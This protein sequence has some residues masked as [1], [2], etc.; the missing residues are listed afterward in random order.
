MSDLA[1]KE[2]DKLIRKTSKKLKKVYKRA[3]QDAIDKFNAH[4]A[5]FH[6]KEIRYYDDYVRTGLWTEQDYKDWRKN[7][8][9][10]SQRLEE[11]QNIIAEDL[12]NTD[13]IAMKMVRDGEFDVYALNHNYST[14]E[15]ERKL[16]I[17]TSFTLY[18][19][20]AVE[21]LVIDDPELLPAPSEK[22]QAEIDAKDLKWNKEKLSSVFTSAIITGVDIPT[23][24]QKIS[25]V[26]SMDY[27]ASIRNA[28]TMYTGAENR[29]RQDSYTRAQRMGIDIRK[30]WIATLDERTRDSHRAVDG[31]IVELNEKFSNGLRFPGDPDGAPGEVYNCRCAMVSVV[32][33]VDPMAFVDKSD[34]LK[35]KLENENITYEEWKKG[36]KKKGD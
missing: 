7:Q 27:N 3:M 19:H 14:Y 18:N 5:S 16:G 9:L 25:E 22:R 13:K 15:I 1:H 20:D 23:L 34:V 4:M 28:R 31:E 11:I 10:V 26:A 17:D 12:K 6:E 24:A 8:L 29:G 35:R 2:T 32:D 30:K 36:H 33:G 21:S